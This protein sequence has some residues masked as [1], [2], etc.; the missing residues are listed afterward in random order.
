MNSFSQDFER[1]Y[2]ARRKED[3]TSKI[4]VST[5]KVYVAEQVEAFFPRTL[6]LL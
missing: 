1:E 2:G 6:P 5:L 3:K 4:K